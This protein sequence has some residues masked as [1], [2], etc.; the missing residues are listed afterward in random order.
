MSCGDSVSPCPWRGVITS[1][2][3]HY[4]KL[5]ENDLVLP[6]AALKRAKDGEEQ[7]RA[8]LYERYQRQMS[9]YNALDFDDL[10]LMPTLL[11][12]GNAE[13]RERWQAKIR[14]L[15]VDEYQDTNS[16]QYVV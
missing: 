16:S 10:I 6:G 1:Y 11:L 3:I 13:V 9:A 2:S 5:Y 8:L 15:L 7:Q 14:Y 4:T 12:Q